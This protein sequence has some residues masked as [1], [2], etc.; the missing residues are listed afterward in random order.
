MKPLLLR[1][2]TLNERIE[3]PVVRF[4]GECN[5]ELVKTYR[6]NGHTVPRGF[7][8]DGASIP[9][10]LWWWNQPSGI[11]FPAAIVHDFHYSHQPVPRKFADRSFYW[12]LIGIGV[13]T[14][15]AWLMWAAVRVFGGK[16]WR[17]HK[18]EADARKARPT[19]NLD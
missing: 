4:H 13:R 2:Q 17:N 18:S 6:L 16:A 8:F 7:R 5:W 15:A 3:R 10:F 9:R 14:T 1:N 12:N 11:A 19:H